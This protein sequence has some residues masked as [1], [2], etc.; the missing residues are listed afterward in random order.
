MAIPVA[1]LATLCSLNCIAIDCWESRFRP[2]AGPTE[3]RFLC[4]GPGIY[5][6][7][8]TAIV[9]AVSALV[10]CFA[11]ANLR[12]FFISSMLSALALLYLWTQSTRFTVEFL[13]VLADVALLTPAIACLLF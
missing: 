6:A 12:P 2:T 13:R 7:S 11:A 1:I 3:F 10:L 8:I 9:A 4:I 5:F